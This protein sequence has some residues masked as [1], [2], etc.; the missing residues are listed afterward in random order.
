MTGRNDDDKSARATDVTLDL[1]EGAIDIAIDNAT[2]SLAAKRALLAATSEADAATGTLA[3]IET[4]G[5]VDSIASDTSDGIS[6][7]IELILGF[8]N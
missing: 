6:D 5:V 2:V 4:A 3:A 8:L 1:T 7:G